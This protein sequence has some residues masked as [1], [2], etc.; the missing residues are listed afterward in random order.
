MNNKDGITK[1]NVWYIYHYPSLTPLPVPYHTETVV[2]ATLLPGCGQ[3]LR[4]GR[5]AR[6]D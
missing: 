2:K 5:V 4:A 3:R 6:L 1:L